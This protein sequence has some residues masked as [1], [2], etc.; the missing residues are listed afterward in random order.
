VFL[1]YSVFLNKK[2][3]DF[4]LEGLILKLESPKTSVVEMKGRGFGVLFEVTYPSAWAP[5]LFNG[6]GSQNYAP[7]SANCY[8]D[9][10][11]PSFW[12]LS[13]TFYSKQNWR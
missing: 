10:S 8:Y 11:V 4:L 12:N 1:K 9:V 2:T 6:A 7:A 13:L 3:A 5:Q